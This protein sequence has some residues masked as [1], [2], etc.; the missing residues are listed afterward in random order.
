MQAAPE[1]LDAKVLRD[2]SLARPQANARLARSPSRRDVL[3]RS[4]PAPAHHGAGAPQVMAAA[5]LATVAQQG[6]RCAGAQVK[7]RRA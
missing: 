3:E 6:L 1:A 7:E 4:E 5:K 2:F